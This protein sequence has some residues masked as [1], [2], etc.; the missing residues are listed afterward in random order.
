M[1]GNLQTKSGIILGGTGNFVKPVTKSGVW[2]P[3]LS[4]QTAFNQPEP[5][6]YSVCVRVPA[7]SPENPG[8]GPRRLLEEYHRTRQTFGKV[9][10]PHQREN[11]CT[12][13]P[14]NRRKQ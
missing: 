6:L 7:A 3:F 8:D 9:L 12:R 14:R 10:Y 5:M 13:N 11:S 4:A 2:R 1:R